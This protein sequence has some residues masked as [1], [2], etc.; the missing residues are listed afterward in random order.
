M[1][2]P[3]PV[4]TATTAQGQTATLTAAAPAGVATGDRQAVIAVLATSGEDVVAA[5]SGWLVA[6]T[7]AMTSTLT[8]ADT[9][10]LVIY[11][12]DPAVDPGSAA[13]SVAKTTAGTRLWS[14]IRFAYRGG[15]AITGVTISTVTTAVTS[16]PL[17]AQT[18]TVANSIVVGGVILDQSGAANAFT[19]TTTQP[20]GWTKLAEIST[21]TSTGTIEALTLGAGAVEQVAAGAVNGT[22]TTSLADDSMVWSLIVPATAPA[23]SS[24]AQTRGFFAIL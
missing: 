13:F 22:Y 3:T 20:A 21:L 17:P 6:A 24:G 10:R 11:T 16:H 23:S 12:P 19:S 2:A 8:A 14:T 1:A 15:P 7:Q 9:T 4:G 5:P 18:T